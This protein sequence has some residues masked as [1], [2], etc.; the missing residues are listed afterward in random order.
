LALGLGAAFAGVAAIA[1]G[2]RLFTHDELAPPK[3]DVAPAE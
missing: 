1:S 3:R 2:M